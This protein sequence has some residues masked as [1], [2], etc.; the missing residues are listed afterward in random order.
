MENIFEKE[1]GSLNTAQKEAVD[2][3]EGPVMV[4][5]GPGTGKTQILAIRIGKILLETDTRPENILCMTYTDSGAIAMRKRLIK[6]IGPDAYKVN[7]HTYHSFCNQVI[8]DNLS[9]FDKNSM[10]PISELESIA[11]VRELIDQFKKGNPLKRYRGDVYYEAQ[12]LLYFFSIMKREGWT[13]S[14][15][16]EGIDRYIE[17][18]P[19]RDEFVYKKK[20]KQFNAGDLKE[21]KINEEKNKM[22]RLTAAI[23]EFEKYQKKMVDRNRYDFDDMINWVIK[24]F[25]EKRELL[26]QYQ[27]Q[28]QYVLVDEYQDTSGTQNKLVELLVSYW[29][30]PNLFVVGDDDQSIFRFQGASV[31]NMLRFLQKYPNIKTIMLTE[32]YRSIQPILDISKSLIDANNERL[33]K[34]IEGLSKILT[35]GKKELQG[36]TDFPVIKAYQ[37]PREEMIGITQSIESLIQNGTEPKRIAVI[38]KENKYGEEIAEFLQCKKINYF[39]KRNLDLLSLP[40]IKKIILFF[41][42]LDAEMDMPF[43]GD[44]MLFEILHFDWFGIQPLEIAK[45]SIENNE[46]LYKKEGSGFRR[47]IEEKTNKVAGSLFEKNI[48]DE[49]AQT[50]RLLETIIGS[51]NNITLQQLLEN[52]IRDTGLLGV[53]MRSQDHHWQLQ[54]LTAFFDFMKNETK[55]DHTLDLRKFVRVIKMKG[56]KPANSSWFK[57]IGI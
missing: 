47:I 16:Q 34:H 48:S 28:F 30:E 37:T 14:M 50:G 19:T 29:D 36:I 11:L 52:I 44:E 33:I 42:Y 2:T 3:T 15:I 27:E 32:N 57:R 18:L 49:L 13:S 9:H 20:Y 53:I 7:I 4:I 55:K 46:R 1:Y 12:N 17:S 5:A 31:D 22:A 25:E 40:L 38:Y 41:E 35:T 24:A 54:T 43:S 21:D 8:Q 45:L 23:A 10:D 51:I 56:C 39:S 6:M 26:A